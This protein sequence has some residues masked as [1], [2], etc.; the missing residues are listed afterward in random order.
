MPRDLIPFS[1]PDVSA[2]AKSLRQQLAGRTAVPSHVEMLNILARASGSRNFQELRANSANGPAAADRPGDDEMVVR[3]AG[4]FDTEGR[5]ISWPA[6][7]S[8]QMLCMWGLWSRL[9]A[10]RVMSEREVSAEIGALHLFGDHAILRR[11]LC[12]LGL[13]TRTKDGREY[14]RVERA[15]TAQA[16]AL[17]HRLKR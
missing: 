14:R 2:L 15:P 9:P 10:G 17:L 6:K 5:L 8:L 11:T 16:A 13:L 7:T 1:S 3:A 12:Q 4:F